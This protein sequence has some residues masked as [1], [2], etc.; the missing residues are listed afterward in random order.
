[1]AAALVVGSIAPAAAQGIC[2]AIAMRAFVAAERRSYGLDQQPLRDALALAESIGGE[3]LARVYRAMLR[4]I[5]AAP[6]MSPRE[7]YLISRNAPCGWPGA[8]PR[9]SAADQIV[10]R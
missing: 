4:D 3:R 10:R 5:P 1:M 8:S 6:Q 9:G 2:D 7:A